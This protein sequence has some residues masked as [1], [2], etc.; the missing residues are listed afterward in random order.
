MTR[1][2]FPEENDR[3]MKGP[4][5]TP[6]PT[7]QQTP[8]SPIVSSPPPTK[9]LPEKVQRHEREVLLVT[10]NGRNRAGGRYW[11]MP[12]WTVVVLQVIISLP[13]YLFAFWV[14]IEGI[15]A[16]GDTLINIIDYLAFR[17]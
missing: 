15:K 10:D 4:L 1:T 6:P 11:G 7:R 13:L 3:L 16:G 14:M 8:A 17:P 2:V 12:E 5:L 9:N